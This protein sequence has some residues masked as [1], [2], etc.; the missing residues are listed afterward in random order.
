MSRESEPEFSST[1]CPPGACG[2]IMTFMNNNSMTRERMI[3]EWVDNSL[4]AKSRL[5]MVTRNKDFVEIRDDGQGC[6][7][8]QA[9]LKLSRSYIH[10]NGSRS[11]MFGMG[12]KIAS[13]RASQG[14]RT[15]VE[16]IHEGQIHRLEANWRLMMERDS[17]SFGTTKPI[18][19]KNGQTGTTI[20]NDGPDG[21]ITFPG[22]ER[23]SERL[24]FDYM[25]AIKSGVLIVLKIDGKRYE[26]KPYRIPKFS[27]ECDFSFDYDGYKIEGMCGIVAAG[28]LNPYPGFTFH[29]GP[30]RVLLTTE[31]PADGKFCGRIQ[32][33]IK[34]P[35]G[36]DNV[37][38]TKDGWKTDDPTALYDMLGGASRHIIDAAQE[39]S[40]DHELATFTNEIESLLN[41]TILVRANGRRPGNSGQQGTVEPKDT[42]R[43]HKKFNIWRPGDRGTAKCSP[44][45]PQRFEVHWRDDI[46]N[47]FDISISGNRKTVAHITLNH[48]RPIIGALRNSKNAYGVF[49]FS[50]MA[51]A[52]HLGINR[53]QQQLFGIVDLFKVNEIFDALTGNQLSEQQKATA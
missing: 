11:G 37:N 32:A 1:D 28:E 10:G 2:M 46:E 6:A 25:D 21:P 51:L 53:D 39:A 41:G 40:E 42:D 12:G 3:R 17:W 15:Y 16:T 44:A 20:I 7:D 8:P 50:A 23:I 35:E 13:L 29:W 36:W 43:R 47:T 34:L 9:I 22:A 4:D 5:V 27:Q 38:V 48:S 45:V 24:G 14:Q 49:S 19:A 33:H 30:H 52:S 18:A 31:D 26:I